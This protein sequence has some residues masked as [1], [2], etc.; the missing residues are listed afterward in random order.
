MCNE[1]QC[2]DSR[3][4]DLAATALGKLVRAKQMACFRGHPM[5]VSTAVRGR[6]CDGPCGGRTGEEVLALATCEKCDWDL[7]LRCVAA[8]GKTGKLISPRIEPR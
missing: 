7:C 4:R 1:E 2:G 3:S 5:V 8:F 6:F